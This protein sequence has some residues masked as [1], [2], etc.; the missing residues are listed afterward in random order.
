MVSCHELVAIQIRGDI[1]Q[2][3]ISSCSCARVQ[4]M[5]LSGDVEGVGERDQGQKEMWKI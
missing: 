3:G 1:A 5:Q 2:Q 4:D